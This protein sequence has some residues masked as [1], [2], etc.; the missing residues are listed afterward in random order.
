MIKIDILKDISRFR[1]IKNSKRPTWEWRGNNTKALFK[2]NFDTSKYNTG[3][4]CGK[5]N[6]ITVVDF[7]AYKVENKDTHPFYKDFLE[8]IDNNFN[9]FTVKTPSGGYHYYFKFNEKIKQTQSSIH[10]DIRATGGYV[11]GPGSVINGKTY[12][13]VNNVPIQNMSEKLE[14]FLLQ[15]LYN[16]KIVKNNRKKNKNIITTET[17]QN[18]Y[19]YDIPQAIKEDILSNLPA[20]YYN[21]YTFWLKFTTACKSLN[22]KKIWENLSGKNDKYNSSNNNK[23]WNGIK[24]HNDLPIVKEIIK[25]SKS[26]NKPLIDYVKYCKIFNKKIEPNRTINSKKLGYE[27]FFQVF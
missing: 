24:K 19:D 7:D 23:I 3:V 8:E 11:V 12:D 27:F 1:L 20:K 5:I 25:M 13:I 21:E 26:K 10:I 6:N 9:T 17:T 16:N 14:A 22:C 15:A 4:I 2:K 18:I